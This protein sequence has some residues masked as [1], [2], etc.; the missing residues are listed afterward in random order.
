[1]KRV[2]LAAAA[3][4]AAGCTDQPALFPNTPERPPRVVLPAGE[5]AVYEQDTVVI[6]VRGDG[7]VRA[8]L[9]A[10][11]SAGAILWRSEEAPITGAAAAVPVSDVGITVPRG[12]A[13]RVTGSVV[14]AGGERF[15]A[16][17]DT[18]AVRT[19]AGSASRTMRLYAGRRV[20]LGSGVHASDLVAAPEL[21][22]AFY[23]VPAEGSIGAL[24]LLDGGKLLAGINAGAA[25][26]KLAYAGGVLAALSADGGELSFMRTGPGG[27]VLIRRTLLPALEIEAD[28]TFVA[29]VRPAGRA[30][31]L[32][33]AAGCGAPV[34]VVPSGLVVLKGSAGTGPGVVRIV[35][36]LDSIAPPRLVLPGYDGAVRGDSSATIAVL[37]PTAPDGTRLLL[38]RRTGASRCLSTSLP[39]LV[40]LSADG[41]LYAGSGAGT[42]PCGP[43]TTVV[44]V[45]TVLSAAPGL[46][47][48]G[49]RNTLAEAR[50]GPVAD[51]Q[52]SDDGSR[53]LVRG[54]SGVAI[55]DAD[56]RV[57]GTL[58]SPGA[59]AA[60][61]LR[62][63]GAPPRIAVADSTGVT[64][65]DAT[66]MTRLAFIP[67]GNTAGPIVFLRQA[68]GDVVAAP[69][70]GG[71]VV[72]GIPAP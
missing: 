23:A 34:A 12:T 25:P 37:T 47:A 9:L 58:P 27:L 2:I 15:Y 32:A 8:Q 46:S 26:T 52:L 18:T 61:W 5:I 53:L 22:V 67:I 68:G 3:L 69:I 70:S 65:Y 33:C 29:A 51:L 49:V 72:A 17:D 40:A 55:A 64:V 44:R 16:S 14:T 62:G 66:R 30:L 60:A 31:A 13:I 28:T 21:G 19:L 6:E 71:F 41:R 59:T 35:P 56:L 50:L 20:R 38:Q 57:L 63:P 36:A 54:D 4:V 24:D 42:P 39:D 7:A 11:D 45:D 10:L 1:M 43:G 48:L